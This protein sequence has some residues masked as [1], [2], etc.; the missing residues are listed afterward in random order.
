MPVS[1][2]EII[3]RYFTPAPGGRGDVE[4][5]VGDDGA[6]LRVPNG[7]ELVVT[8]DT[9]VREVHFSGDDPP[10][11]I[12]Y[13]ALA[14]NLSD[15]AAMAAQPAWATLAL[16]LPRADEDWIAAFARG[17]FDLAERY[18]VALVGGDLTR[19]PLTVTV[20]AYGLVPAGFCLRRNGARPGDEI[21][22][23]GTLGDAA[24][25]LADPSSAGHPSL[26][27]RLHRPEPRVAEG[28][29]LRGLASSAIDV[30]DG[31]AAD[32][33]HLLVQSGCGAT[34]YL[35]ELPLSSALLAVEDP[36][37][38]YALALAGGDDYE[39]CFTLPPERRTALES[40][41]KGAPMTRIG[42]IEAT[43]GIRWL[44]ADGIAYPPTEEGYRHF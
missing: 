4:A 5:G 30:S 22:V 18:E 24:L 38:R 21:F 31:L 14:V 6:V 2:F 1:E 32:L 28:L 34:V 3:A 10:E 40:R 19:G 26:L 12:G 17:F 27:A 44:G 42:R 23:T 29:F 8:T 11:D 9:L 15:L 41:W 43:P 36:G 13:K 16:T 39:L 25:A 33:G 7:S 37:R 35:A 20:G